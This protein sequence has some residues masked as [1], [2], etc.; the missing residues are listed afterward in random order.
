MK[1]SRWAALSCGA[2]AALLGALALTGWLT[3]WRR[4]SSFRSDYIPM[5]P[6][7]AL[8]FLVLSA[9]VGALTAGGRW[10]YRLAKAG[11]AVV[12]GVV[13][14]RL[15]EVA[16]GADLQVDRWIFRFPAETLGLAPV[17]VMAFPTALNFLFASVSL[18]LLASSRKARLAN[19][20]AGALAVVVTFIGLVFSLGYVYG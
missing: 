7:T 8:S 6:N 13:A 1:W 18:F 16:T 5:A 11:A 19:G 12:F 17:G 2:V 15:S 10:P 14:F 9:G 3:G 4:L 20:V